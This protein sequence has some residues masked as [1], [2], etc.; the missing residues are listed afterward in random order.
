MYSSFFQ[1]IRNAQ[2]GRG[3]IADKDYTMSAITDCVKTY[4]RNVHKQFLLRRDPE[5]YAKTLDNVRLRA[6]RQGVG[7]CRSLSAVGV[8][9]KLLQRTN[10]R[11]QATRDFCDKLG[12]PIN[13]AMAM[14]DTDH[15][16]E[17]QTCGSDTDLSDSTTDRRV[18]AGLGQTAKKMVGFEW[19]SPD[20]SERS[21]NFITRNLPGRLVCRLSSLADIQV[22]QWA[23]Y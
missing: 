20:V 4:W 19:R 12:I 7:V 1:R 11:R 5:R 13:D 10:T 23:S 18:K 2:N 22:V 8:L 6:R 17:A 21:N 15:A 16:S 14:L 9:K 3:E